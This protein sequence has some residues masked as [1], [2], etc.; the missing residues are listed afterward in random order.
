MKEY[1]SSTDRLAARLKAS[2][3][4][5]QDTGVPLV[6]EISDQ[7]QYF[8]KPIEINKSSNIPDV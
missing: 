3:T 1:L 8:I 6:Q 2:M 7:E 5:N 4:D